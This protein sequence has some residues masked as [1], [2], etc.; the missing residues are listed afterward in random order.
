[1]TALTSPVKTRVSAET[2]TGTTHASAPHHMLGSNA[3][4]VGPPNTENRKDFRLPVFI[5]VSMFKLKNG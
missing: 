4:Y 3:I 2:L 1:M 5:D